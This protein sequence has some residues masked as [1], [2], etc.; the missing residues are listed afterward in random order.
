MILHK[1]LFNMN[2]FNILKFGEFFLRNGYVALLDVTTFTSPG[3][4][5]AH[6]SSLF[7]LQ[8]RANF[9]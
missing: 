2:A 8:N 6:A 3:Y 5:E 4:S 1:D 7:I 9:T